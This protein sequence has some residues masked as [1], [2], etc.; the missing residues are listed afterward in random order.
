MV[1]RDIN[2]ITYR[3]CEQLSIGVLPTKRNVLE[4]MLYL[5]RPGAPGPQIKV[6]EA[7]NIL[8]RN[9]TR[10]WGFAN[11]YTKDW[12]YVAK[13]ITKLYKTA[14]NN[15]R[16][17]AKSMKKVNNGKR[18]WIN[19]ILVWRNYLT[20]SVQMMLPEKT[21]RNYRHKDEERRV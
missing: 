5:M 15:W 4:C 1:L 13:D 17:S 18:I 16:Y 9:L 11:I 14:H 20:Y 8:A 10:H 21:G 2:G 6:E 7:S 3:P 12:R 19:S